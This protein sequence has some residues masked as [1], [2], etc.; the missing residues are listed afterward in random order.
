MRK[1][2]KRDYI[3]C[4]AWYAVSLLIG[5]FALPLM[6]LREWY[7]WKRYH[8]PHIEGDDIFRYGIVIGLGTLTRVVWEIIKL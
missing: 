4:V 2:N 5:V 7:Q 6:I 3:G 1:M 8:L